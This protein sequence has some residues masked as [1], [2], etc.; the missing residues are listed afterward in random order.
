MR[1]SKINSVPQNIFVGFFQVMLVAGKEKKEQ[2]KK[3][4]I[5]KRCG[6]FVCYYFLN[7]TLYTTMISYY[8]K[9]ELRLIV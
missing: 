4:C 1:D 9:N 3:I 2:Q 7:N 8:L 5:D 6:F